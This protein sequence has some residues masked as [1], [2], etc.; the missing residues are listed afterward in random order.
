MPIDADGRRLGY[1]FSCRAAAP[2]L[3]GDRRGGWSGATLRGAAAGRVRVG[4]RLSLPRLPPLRAGRGTL[5]PD[6]L[7][8]GLDGQLAGADAPGR[9]VSR[10]AAALLLARHD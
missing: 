7:G 3:S 5:R 6:P 4:A 8:D 10:Q 9:A 1:R 2:A